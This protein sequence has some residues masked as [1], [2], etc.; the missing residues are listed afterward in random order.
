M[1]KTRVIRVRRFY[2]D[3]V[4]LIAAMIRPRASMRR[5][6]GQP[7]G[8]TGQKGRVKKGTQDDGMTYVNISS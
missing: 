5:D 1:K 8:K 7:I 3:G 4:P 6:R 2:F